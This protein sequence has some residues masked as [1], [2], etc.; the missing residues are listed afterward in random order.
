MH[1]MSNLFDQLGLPS[2]QAAIESFIETHSPLAPGV[3]LSEAPFWT[4]AQASFLR[5]EIIEDADWAEVVDELNA[6][7]RVRG[8]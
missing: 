6:E 4:P 3:L 1:S 2:D 8:T 7:L 5:E